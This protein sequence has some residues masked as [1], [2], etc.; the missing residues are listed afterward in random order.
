MRAAPFVPALLAAS[1]MGGTGS[2]AGGDDT[3]PLVLSLE[4]QANAIWSALPTRGDDARLTL[5]GDTARECAESALRD[6]QRM[7]EQRIA[8]ERAA[9][10][11]EKVP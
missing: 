11:T 1:L 9:S 8:E 7:L 6:A 5:A 2:A 4:D 3:V 10:T